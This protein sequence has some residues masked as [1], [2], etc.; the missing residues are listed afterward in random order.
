[1]AALDELFH[2]FIN[3]ACTQQEKQAL[4]ALMARPGNDAALQRLIDDV[5]AS[6]DEDMEVAPERAQEILSVI[7][8]AGT[9]KSRPAKI[10]SILRPVAAAAA[11]LLLAGAAYYLLRRP[12]QVADPAAPVA[13][14][15]PAATSGAVLTLADGSKVSL[16]S[17]SQGLI[18]HQG[19][20]S[21]TLA[22]GS[23]VYN[24]NGAE[25]VA[26]NTL[27][28]PRGR[29]FHITLPDGSGVWLNAASTL[30]YPTSFSA[31]ERIVELN[32]EAYFDI[33]PHAN[34]PFKVKAGNNTEILV[35]GTGFNV[36]AYP[37]D[38]QVAT[39]LLH[40]KVSVNASLLQPGQQAQVAAGGQAVNVL[41]ADTSQVMAWKNGMF[42]FENASIS[43]VMKQLERW[44][45]IDVQFENGV[46]AMQ[47]G[48][49]IERGLSLMHITRILEISNV[50]CRLEGRKLIVTQ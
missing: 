45:D 15:I 48:G 10:F 49:K 27:N 44:Y 7:L 21:V 29:V 30:R 35:L 12:A 38:A 32:G 18:A 40:G 22:K 19:G 43:E 26:Y 8:K 3:G 23:V 28:T 37:N 42:N 13:Q 24:S 20:A 9:E 31:H 5:I 36:S 17:L 4:F 25:E 14:D 33:Q 16:D 39:T 1:M 47:F 46:P 50:H 2:K 11:I 6:T 34:A 41:P